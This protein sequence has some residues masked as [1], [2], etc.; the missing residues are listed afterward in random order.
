MDQSGFLSDPEGHFYE[1]N[2]HKVYGFEKI[3]HFPCLVLLGEPG[4]GKS[5][6]LQDAYEFSQKQGRSTLFVDLKG[7]SEFSRI[8]KMIFSSTEYVK[9]SESDYTLDVFLDSLDE[10][11]I[12]C[13]SL[14]RLLAKDLEKRL[15]DSALCYR[16]NIR[17]AC[18]TADWQS[19]F[20]ALD[21]SLTNLWGGEKVG[22]YELAPL[23]RRDVIAAVESE[24]LSATDFIEQVQSRRAISLAIKPVTLN[25]LLKQFRSGNGQLAATQVEIYETG[26]LELA[27]ELDPERKNRNLHFDA[28]QRL[29]VAS[30]IAAIT[31]FGR[32]KF[33]LLEQEWTEISADEI[34]ISD[35]K[36]YKEAT[37]G[38]DFVVN[39]QEINETLRTA[40]FSSGGESKLTWAHQTYAEFLAAR[41][42]KNH[43]LSHQQLLNL[44][45]HPTDSERRVIPQLRETAAWLASMEP[46]VFESLLACDPETLLRSDVTTVD[47]QMREALV[48]GLLKAYESER[49]L[50]RLENS[51]DRYKYL[52]HPNLASQLR[53]YLEDKAGKWT[54]RD[55]VIDVV[56][57]NKLVELED[58]LL[59]LAFDP[60]EHKQVGKSAVYA[61]ARIATLETKL[62]LIPFAKGIAG[63]DPD[64]DFKGVALGALW[65]SAISVEELLE[66]LTPPKQM[67]YFGSYKLFLTRLFVVDGLSAEQVYKILYWLNL[68]QDSAWV[69]GFIE[70]YGRQSGET[71][72]LDLLLRQALNYLDY[73][74]MSKLLA[75]F[76]F[77]RYFEEHFHLGSVT[78][79]DFVHDLQSNTEKRRTLVT[80]IVKHS[81]I[82]ENGLGILGNSR[83]GFELVGEADLDWILESL[84]LEPDNAIQKRWCGLVRH[85]FDTKNDEQFSKVFEVYQRNLELKSQLSRWFAAVELN[86][87]LADEM[88]REHSLELKRVKEAAEWEN[89]RNFLLSPPPEER[90]KRWVEAAKTDPQKWWIVTR[91]LMLE[92]TDR[93]YNHDF[94]PDITQFYGWRNADETMRQEIIR[95]AREYLSKG[96]SYDSDWLGKNKVDFRAFAGYKALW[97][98]CSKQFAHLESL[99]SA[100]WKKWAAI[101][102][103][104]PNMGGRNDHE[105][106]QYLLEQAYHYAPE[107]TIRALIAEAKKDIQKHN[108]LFGTNRLDKIWDSRL[109]EAFFG[110]F[111]SIKL[112]PKAF[113]ELLDLLIKHG[114]EPARSLALGH[115]SK[116]KGKNQRLYALRSAEALINYPLDLNN[117][118]ADIWSILQS[119][120]SFAREFLLTVAGRIAP[121]IEIRIAEQAVA[122]LY[123]YIEQEFPRANDPNHDNDTMAHLVTPMDEIAQWRGRLIESLANR[124][125]TQ[126][127]VAL[128]RI[129]QIFPEQD[130]L[131]WSIHNAKEALRTRTWEPLDPGTILEIVQKPHARL[132]QSP[133]QLSQAILE[134]LERLQQRLK[135]E[136]PM[137]RFLWNEPPGKG[138][139]KFRPKD[140]NSLSDFIKL[141]LEADLKGTGVILNR[142]VEIRRSVVTKPGERTDILVDIA[143]PSVGILREKIGVIIEVKGCWNKDLQTS[144]KDQLVDRYLRDN[145]GRDG[146]YLVGWYM[147]KQW[148]EKHGQYKATKRLGFD[149]ESARAYFSQQAKA[150]SDLLASVES[151]ILDVGLD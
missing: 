104:F 125:T 73:P 13:D 68:R 34:R 82:R 33:V 35:L 28:D 11:A 37:K 90:V 109:S 61:L 94:E 105:I 92:P 112:Q 123:I 30:R 48:E 79:A 24:G 23:R 119:D 47:S 141:H 31:I 131:K 51:K 1:H 106:S 5:H 103:T 86:S 143:L 39:E 44:V 110:L 20:G 14:A 80:Q 138:K 4:Q 97:L 21:S 77:G 128:E 115:L 25:F 124:G 17:F 121:P 99:D 15:S 19:G 69:Y 148:D 85:T 71:G 64:D 146:I 135:G 18:R 43:G 147:C 144:L 53:P 65:P 76:V 74:G 132:I 3:N 118:W 114:W 96:E 38:N 40:L 62:K 63:E 127:V 98:L 100:E 129:R 93:R 16:I 108:F 9:W 72:G 58:S 133:K 84:E 59:R 130:W 2:S 41:Y 91:D 27:K 6:A 78:N 70:R 113:G 52:K 88:R 89:K 83:R 116:R 50:P 136:T 10:C 107:E 49:L 142:E 66:C 139:P 42:L 67:N 32:K 54:T 22:V 102:V 7:E 145:P 134:S 75:D 150:N 126:A 149:L 151:V 46:T 55:F 111:G 12:R 56:E 137:T 60:T 122:D 117:L 26:C 57:A 87:S 120:K 140:E 36:G 45:V 8:E 29:E 95:G 101:I 81:S